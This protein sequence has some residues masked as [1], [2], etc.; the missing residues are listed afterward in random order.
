MSKK[1]VV[2]VVQTRTPEGFPVNEGGIID[3]NFLECLEMGGLIIQH[4]VDPNGLTDKCFDIKPPDGLLDEGLW[5]ACMTDRMRDLGF[6][7]VKA[8]STE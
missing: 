6:N 5:I 1:Y 3:S 7:A 8:P 2:R 4:P